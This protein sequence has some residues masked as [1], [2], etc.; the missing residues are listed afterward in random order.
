[1][2]KFLYSFLIIWGKM[3][4][5][6][7]NI[8]YSIIMIAIFSMISGTTLAAVISGSTYDLYLNKIDDVKVTI[9]TSPRQT[10]IAKD[11]EYSFEVGMGEYRITAEKYREGELLYK[12]EE[13]ISVIDDGNYVIDLILF[14]NFDEEE[15]IISEASNIDIPVDQDQEDKKNHDN[16]IL[17]IVLCVLVIVFL[18]ASIPRARNRED[19]HEEVKVSLDHA[20]LDDYS[21]QVVEAIKEHGG[22][23]TQKDVRKKI[24]LSEAKVSLIIS[25]LESKG[26]IE[27]IKKG[28]GNIIILK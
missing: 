18:V 28:R 21:R 20:G 2:E 13:N 4:S 25:E 1:M 9:D 14:P 10:M 16:L 5:L 22:R 12:T 27:K 7:R 26:V 17:I 8:L 6:T 19:S 24:P 15:D 11:S 3:A 23:A